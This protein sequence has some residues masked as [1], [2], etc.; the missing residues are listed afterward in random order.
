MLEAVHTVASAAWHFVF[1]ASEVILEPLLLTWLITL[2]FQ[3]N[4]KQDVV[5][6]VL[7]FKEAPGNPSGSVVF[8]DGAVAL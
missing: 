7:L 1:G 3:V 4:W 6:C 5:Y 2:P 8:S